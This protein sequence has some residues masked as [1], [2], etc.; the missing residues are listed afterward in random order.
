MVEA[1]IVRRV[2][3][4]R[5]RTPREALD[6]T[7]R[8]QHKY[9]FDYFEIVDTMPKAQSNEVEIVFFKPDLSERHNY[10]SDDDLEKEY[11]LRG[12]K[13]ADPISVS[14]VNELDPKFADRY[15]NGTHWKN[16]HG[17]WCIAAFGRFDG[18]RC[19]GVHRQTF[20]WYGNWWFAGICK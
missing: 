8:E 9:G 11:E 3:V 15:L 13:P 10:I 6:A 2:L 5:T 20:V 17:D 16:A 12:L 14:A 7:G 4:N 1:R 18:Q 19:V